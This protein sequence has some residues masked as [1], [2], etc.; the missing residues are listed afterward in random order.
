[1]KICLITN[2]YA[3]Y[4][5]GGAEIYVRKI[6]EELAQSNEV[7]I[8]TTKPYL[9]FSSFVPSISIENKIKIYRFYP[10]NV[11][12]IYKRGKNTLLKMLWYILDLYNLHSYFVV[13]KILKKEKPDIVHTH[14]VRGMSN[15][16]FNAIR[17]LS[18]P[19]IHTVHDLYFLCPRGTLYNSNYSLCREPRVICKMYRKFMHSQVSNKFDMVLFPSE[20]YM[21]LHERSSFFS[22]TTTLSIPN[23]IEID[24]ENQS[25][26][27]IKKNKLSVLYI[28]N[29]SKRKGVMYAVQAVKELPE[30]KIEFHIAGYGNDLEY[31]KETA[32]F[33]K[34][35]IFHGFVEGNEKRKLF[36]NIDVSILPSMWYENAPISI[37][38]SFKYSIPVMASNIG[39]IPELIKD[40][41]NGFLFTPG[42]VGSIKSCLLKLI[43]NP[44]VLLKMKQNSLE[45]S[46]KYDIENHIKKIKYF[47][48][49]VSKC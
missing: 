43:I 5:M 33:C 34:N 41:F 15:S 7:I 48:K 8:I 20:Y 24:N 44:E 10:F 31:C 32:R 16:V 19:V 2:T 1:M 38:E 49:M 6:A 45:S 42:D 11:L 17:Y 12:H 39:G 29:I 25:L 35:I 22:H 26:S 14:N 37:L 40:G 27:K 46:K 30:G 47:Y 36:N 21:M 9:R 23:G 3:P 13:K 18:I 28:G 4:V